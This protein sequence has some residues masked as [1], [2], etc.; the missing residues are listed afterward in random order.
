MT[1][2]NRTELANVNRGRD[3]TRLSLTVPPPDHYWEMGSLDTFHTVNRKAAERT[4][5]KMRP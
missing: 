5:A 2:V 3:G 4:I 1:D